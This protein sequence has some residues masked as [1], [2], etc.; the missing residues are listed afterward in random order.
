[1]N[2]VTKTLLVSIITN[3]FLIV[4]KIVGGLIGNSVSVVASGIHS[5]SDLLTDIFSIVGAKISSKPADEHHPFGHGKIENI[6]SMGIGVFIIG[7]GL[8]LLKDVFS[9]P[10]KMPSIWL[11][12][13]IIITIIVRYFVLIIL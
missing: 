6:F 10:M 7:M 4:L 13:L 1:M 9:L 5:I 3:F 2:K 8:F 12:I 11:L